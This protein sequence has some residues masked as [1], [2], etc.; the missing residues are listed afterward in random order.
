M[1]ELMEWSPWWRLTSWRGRQQR[2]RGWTIIFQGLL[3][4]LTHLLLQKFPQPP[5]IMEVLNVLDPA[6]VLA[7]GTFDAHNLFDSL[8]PFWLLLSSRF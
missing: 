5:R 6:I 2:A 7:L 3:L 4:V 1:A 8:L